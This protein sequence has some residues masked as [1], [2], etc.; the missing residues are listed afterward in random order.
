MYQ[1]WLFN[2]SWFKVGPPSQTVAG[3]PIL[4]QHWTNVSCE[5]KASIANIGPQFDQWL[6]TGQ[7]WSSDRRSSLRL[8]MLHAI[9]RKLKHISS[10]RGL[11][12]FLEGSSVK[13]LPGE[14]S[15]RPDKEGPISAISD[16]T[17]AI[18][19]IGPIYRRIYSAVI[20]NSL[21]FHYITGRL[22]HN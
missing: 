20:T 9:H 2:Q 10:G 16:S 18:K 19:D 13:L 1:A 17:W 4:N 12:D 7:G 14:P 21:Y 3:G 15:D 5:V 11:C 6:L 8:I 22:I